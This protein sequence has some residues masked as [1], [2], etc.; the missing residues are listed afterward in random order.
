ME[1]NRINIRDFR[2]I[3]K[4]SLEF[5]SGVNILCG[6]NAQGKTNL[7]EAISF[8][9]IGKSFR[10]SHDEE[11]IR[12]SAESCEISLDFTD[13]VRRQNITVR[14]MPGKR[15]HIE[16]NRV[17]IGRVSDIVGV[18]RTVLFCPEH[19]SLIKDGPGERRN[20]L[21]I[22]LSQLYPVYMKSLQKYN[23]ILKQRNQLI[24]DAQEDRRSFDATVEFWS[25]QLA[26]EAALISRYRYRY[27]LSASS[28]IESCFYEM[29]GEKEKPRTLYCGSSKQ[30]PEEYEDLEKTEARYTELLMSH[31]DREIGAGSTLWGIHKD[32]V[33]IL[34]NE[35]PARQFAS[36]GQ[37]RS[38]ALSMKLAEGEVC[39]TVCGEKP[40]FLFDDVF[41]ELDSSRRGYLSGKMKDRQVIITTCEPS[42]I[43]GGKLIRVEKGSFF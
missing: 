29:M 27:L 41:S 22:A 38:L 25:A 24:R 26:H 37:Q 1:C 7:L 15:K 8:A 16:H 3:E 13:S 17:K 35:K 31:H 39:A 36:Q 14:M 10:T 19:L 32:D 42:G 33:E 40:V 6:E 23:Q 5:D 30:S 4:A 18:F 9:S 12:F 43:R 20:Y 11:M 34:L 2:N 21:D 28:H